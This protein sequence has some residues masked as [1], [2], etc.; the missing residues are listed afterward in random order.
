MK[1]FRPVEVYRSVEFARDWNT[2]TLLTFDK[3]LLSNVQV[4]LS[5]PK[6]VI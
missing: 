6:L 1:N 2:G 3:E 5:Q 4:G